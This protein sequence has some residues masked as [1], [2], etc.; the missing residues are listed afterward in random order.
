MRKIEQKDVIQWDSLFEAALY[1]ESPLREKLMESVDNEEP[2]AVL[3]YDLLVENKFY[4][5]IWDPVLIKDLR[6]KYFWHNHWEKDLE[7]EVRQRLAHAILLIWDSQLHTYDLSN[8]KEG[9]EAEA[10]LFLRIPNWR[11]S[12]VRTLGNGDADQEMFWALKWAREAGLIEFQL[13]W[14]EFLSISKIRPNFSLDF[15]GLTVDQLT[16]QQLQEAIIFSD[17]SNLISE[18]VK[19]NLLPF[20]PSLLRSWQKRNFCSEWLQKYVLPTLNLTF[21]EAVEIYPT[22]SRATQIA[23]WSK[24]KSEQVTNPENVWFYSVSALKERLGIEGA[25]EFDYEEMVEELFS[26]KSKAGIVTTCCGDYVQYFA[27]FKRA[28]EFYEETASVNTGV[29]LFEEHLFNDEE[30]FMSFNCVEA[31]PD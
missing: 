10:F 4:V 11:D 30:G 24:F 22:A 5:E 23:I 14:K 27:D 8:V 3:A 26:G 7:E 15:V 28:K 12:I 17:E 21:E 2:W 1:P 20:M 31:R 29:A 18:M 6:Q 16:D 25:P 19:R 13:T 9:L